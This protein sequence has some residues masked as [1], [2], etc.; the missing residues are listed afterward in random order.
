MLLKIIGNRNNE[1]SCILITLHYTWYSINICPLKPV[2]LLWWFFF[3]S[4]FLPS[5]FGEWVFMIPLQDPNSLC[6]D[7]QYSPAETGTWV[8]L[9]MESRTPSDSEYM[10]AFPPFPITFQFLSF[11]SSF[12]FWILAFSIYLWICQSQPFKIYSLLYFLQPSS[13]FGWSMA[14]IQVLPWYVII[15]LYHSNMHAQDLTSRI[16]LFSWWHINIM[17]EK[18][19]Q[20]KNWR[21]LYIHLL[22]I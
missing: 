16:C 13:L 22:S 12:F 4:L 17:K 14:H 1:P 7:P 6:F 19:Q 18:S 21:Y 9:L 11:F 5:L 2:F 10:I 8:V 20:K 15:P 3:S